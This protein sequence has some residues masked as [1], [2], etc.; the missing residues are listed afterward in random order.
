MAVLS[1]FP[2]RSGAGKMDDSAIRQARNEDQGGIVA[3]VNAAYAKYVPRMGK[4]PAPMLADYADLIA[5]GVVHVIGAPTA[6]RG[7]VVSFPAADHYFLENIAVD[8]AYQ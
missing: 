5:H 2:H 4:K 6:I 3:C 1:G 7:V 8:P